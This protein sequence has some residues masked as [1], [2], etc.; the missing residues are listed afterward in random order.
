MATPNSAQRLSFHQTVS[1]S[2][3]GNPTGE[4]CMKQETFAKYFLTIEQNKPKNKN[5]QINKQI[6][7]S[8]STNFCMH[9]E[10]KLLE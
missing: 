3:I 5:K 2:T 4:S 1:Q 7:Q 8:T 10:S 6:L 9:R